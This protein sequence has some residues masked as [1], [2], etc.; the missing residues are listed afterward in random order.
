MLSIIDVC[1]YSVIMEE[2]AQILEIETLIP[3]LLQ[4]TNVVDGAR[5]KRVVMIGD[6]YQLPPIVTN[7]VLQRHSKLEQSMFARFI[8]LGVPAVLLDKQGRSRPEIASLYSWRYQL[9]ATSMIGADHVARATTSSLDNL[10][11][12][13]QGRYLLANPGFALTHQ[14]INVPDF[15]G[16]GESTP[17]AYFYQNLGEA[18]YVVAV[19]QYMRLLGYPRASI[20]ILTTY[21][22]QRKLIQDIAARRCQTPMFGVPIISTVDKFQGQQS[23]Y[24]LLSLVRTKA[25]G[26]IQDV[27]R[28]VVALSRARLGLYVFGRQAVF[29][30]SHDL[31][32]AFSQLTSIGK[33]TELQLTVGEA[34]PTQRLAADPVKEPLVVVTIP[35]VTAMGVLVYRMVQQSQS[36]NPSAVAAAAADVPMAVEDNQ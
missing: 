18:E 33:P 16:Q 20:A 30:A 13:R 6:H 35:D 25:I 19:Y 28:L 1:N 14:L 15:Q 26:H 22:G 9:V 17:S 36:L 29:Q 3:M 2:A 7:P 31:A 34:V 21:N 24:V 32:P 10:D 8:R 11:Q 5:L 27:R 23:D 4:T 12:V